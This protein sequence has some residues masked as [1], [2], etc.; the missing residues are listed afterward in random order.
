MLGEGPR[1]PPGLLGV[2]I[3]EAPHEETPRHISPELS[4]IEETAWDRYIA[5]A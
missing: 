3:E 1:Y 2:V 5:E 4:R